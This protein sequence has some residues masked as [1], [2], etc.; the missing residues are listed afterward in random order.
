MP[1]I[2]IVF[3]SAAGLVL[4]VMAGYPLLLAWMRRSSSRPVAK[5]DVEPTVTAIVAVHNG[6]RYLADKL[7]SL[8][9]LEY[10]REK[11]DVVVVSDGSTDATA[12]IARQFEGVELLELPRGGKCAALNAGIQK[13]HGEILLLTDVRQIVE[14]GALRRLV[15]NFADPTVGAVSGHLRIR[16]GTARDETDIG[17]YWRFETWIRDSLAAI[18]SMFGA[19]GPFY[20]LRRR[21][22]VPLPPDTLLDDMYLPLAAFRRGYRLVVESEAVAW[23]FPMGRNVEFRRKLRTMAGNYQL[24]VRCPWLLTPANRM[25]LHFW[26]YKV[27]RLVLPELLLLIGVSSW[28]LAEPYRQAALAAQAVFYGLALADPWLAQRF[29]LK[30]LSSPARTFLVMLIAALVGLKVFFV[31]A[32]RLWEVTGASTPESSK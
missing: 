11:L 4:Y 27:G 20:S 5:S 3:L 25:W 28:F 24:W 21:L 1:G 15:S 10:P 22:A 30:K 16:S 23:D 9:G 18:D 26:S 19:T 13:A 2:T 6:A 17:L 14:P 31:P 32:G 8:Q 29:P 12:E 7:R